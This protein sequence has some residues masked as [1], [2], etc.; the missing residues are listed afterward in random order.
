M[1]LFFDFFVFFTGG[2]VFL[3]LIVNGS[4]TQ[5]LL[6]FLDMNKLSSAKEGEIHCMETPLVFG[7]I[8]ALGNEDADHGR[9]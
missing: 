9:C 4:T 1:T 7:A 8:N 6:D 5:F 2:I 3:T